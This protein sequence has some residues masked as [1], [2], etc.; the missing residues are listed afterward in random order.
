MLNYFLFV[1]RFLKKL[2]VSEY[3]NY[4]WIMGGKKQKIIRFLV[5]CVCVVLASSPN[6][7]YTAVAA[8]C[9]LTNA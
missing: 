6:L 4:E 8:S 7:I 5:L 9:Q 1:C 2:S 3:L